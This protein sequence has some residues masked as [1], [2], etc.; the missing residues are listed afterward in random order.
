MK[1]TLCLILLLFTTGC[2]SVSS[3]EMQSRA[4]ALTAEGKT[5]E[6]AAV[7]AS[8]EFYPYESSRLVRYLDNGTM[9]YLNGNYYQA[10]R[11]FDQAQEAAAELYTQSISKTIL[12][13][14]A[15]QGLADYVGE[16]YELS[17]L[18]FYQS[19]CHYHLYRK[20]IYEAY[21]DENGVPVPERTLNDA[22][23]RRHLSAARAA[24]LDWDT[25]LNDYSGRSAGENRFKTDMA[26]KTWGG[27]VHQNY[28]TTTDIQIARQLYRDVP[29]ILLQNYSAYPAFNTKFK[30][31]GKDYARLPDLPEETVRR[32]YTAE[33]PHAGHLKGY[34]SSSLKK[35]ESRRTDNV[36]ILM[37]TG[38]ITLKK[39]KRS[40]YHIP[41]SLLL[42]YSGDSKFQDFVFSVMAGQTIEFEIPER[43]EPPAPPA[44]EALIKKAD[45]KIAARAPMALTEPLSEIAYAEYQRIRGRLYSETTARLA[46]KHA[47][48]LAAA[49]ASYDENNPSSLAFARLSYSLAKLGIEMSESADL[50]Y[51]GTLPANIWIQSFRLPAGRYVLEIVSDGRTAERREFEVRKKGETL[52]DLNIFREGNE[53]PPASAP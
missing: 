48:A 36:H 41:M 43:V 22:E 53:K 9:L 2:R 49:Y 18:R 38:L 16:R 24:L 7:V 3:Y 13:G 47:A 45:G 6:A 14:A 26:A 19:L 40:S 34:A 4:R 20:G 5:K 23:K 51:W 31:F 44:Y 52:I 37:K 10:L 21:S 29:K 30:E 1:K 39:K 35:L 27:F 12:A 42:G 8:S 15:G 25:L 50:R 17:L 33:T 11:Q 28:G 32:R 46:A